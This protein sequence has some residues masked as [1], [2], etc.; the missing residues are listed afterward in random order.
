MPEPAMP[1]PAMPEPA[2]PEP[3]MPKPA[4][5][6]PVVS[7]TEVVPQRPWDMHRPMD[8]ITS[9]YDLVAVDLRILEVGA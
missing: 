2:M 6:E 9:V 4:R 7:S 5:P 8:I 1:E 3:A